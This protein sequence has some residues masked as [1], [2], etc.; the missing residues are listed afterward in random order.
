MSPPALMLAK[1]WQVTIGIR[2][3]NVA[4]ENTLL[5]FLRY[6]SI[7]I[8][9]YIST[10]ELIN[11]LREGREGKHILTKGKQ[12]ETFS[13]TS[14]FLLKKKTIHIHIC[15][16]VGAKWQKNNYLPLFQKVSLPN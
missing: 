5:M 14:L 9:Q 12:H 6:K 2:E 7:N 15:P 3:K 4:L 11:Y 8:P 1:H 10:R 13:I 16:G